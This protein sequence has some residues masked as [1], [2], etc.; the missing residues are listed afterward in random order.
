MCL[1]DIVLLLTFFIIQARSHG[2]TTFQCPNG[3]YLSRFSSA[4]DGQERYYKFGCSKFAGQLLV[5]DET[6]TTTETATTENG[7]MYLS[8]G[9]E[10]YTVGIE[11]IENVAPKVD[12]WQLLCCKSESV[13]IRHNDC[14]ETKFVNDHRRPSTFSSAAQVI[15]R[16]QAISESGDRRWWLQICPVDLELKKPSKK[17]DIRARRQVPWDWGRGR[18]PVFPQE[19]NTVLRQQMKIEEERSQQ[20]FE[21][22]KTSNKIENSLPSIIPPQLPPIFQLPSFPRAVT[23]PKPSSTFSSSTTPS[24]TTKMTEKPIEALDY[25]DMYDENFDKKKHTEGGL[26]KGLSEFIQNVQDGLLVAQAAL[27]QDKF[28][29]HIEVTE[30]PRTTSRPKFMFATDDDS[31]Q[32]GS[33]L[34]QSDPNRSHGPKPARP[35]SL[36]SSV[37]VPV[38][39]EVNSIESMLQMIGLCKGGHLDG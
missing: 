37:Q 34:Q 23:I 33:F 10:Q 38:R 24:T 19:Y 18:F 17:S 7:D 32:I 12:S 21:H 25:Y 4:F 39:H 6:C 16:W 36:D 26:F 13:K 28:S 5:F 15:R 14:V 1:K 11:V 31:L 2:M 22:L 29:F 9:S 20:L 8:C 30:P 27:P 3:F 35:N